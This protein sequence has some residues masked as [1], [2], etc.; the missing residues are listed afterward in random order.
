MGIPRM[1]A[2][3]LL[4]TT[5]LGA[6]KMSMVERWLNLATQAPSAR[7]MLFMTLG[8]EGVAGYDKIMKSA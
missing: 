1:K 3:P 4:H 7:I 8:N 5:M 2:L 6:G